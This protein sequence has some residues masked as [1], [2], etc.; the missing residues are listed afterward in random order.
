MCESRSKFN[1][2][3]TNCAPKEVVNCGDRSEELEIKRESESQDDLRIVDADDHADVQREES[4]NPTEEVLSASFSVGSCVSN[5]EVKNK[6]IANNNS[7]HQHNISSIQV[8]QA[9]CRVPDD[10][11]WLMSC[12]RMARLTL[13]RTPITVTGSS[14]APE[15]TSRSVTRALCWTHRHWLL[16][17]EDSLV[18]CGERELNSETTRPSWRG[19]WHRGSSAH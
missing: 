19:G 4:S 9:D 2:D 5:A 13:S 6:T 17:A 14:P 8:I 10:P 15:A 18:R 7:F 11:F 12:A 1:F 3:T 16:P